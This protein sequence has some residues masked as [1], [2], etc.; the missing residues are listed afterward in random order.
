MSF[1]PIISNSISAINLFESILIL[2]KLRKVK[3]IK[4]YSFSSGYCAKSDKSIILENYFFKT[5]DNMVESPTTRVVLE[6]ISFKM[7]MELI[8]Q[9]SQGNPVDGKFVYSLHDIDNGDDDT[10]S[11]GEGLNFISGIELDTIT[12]STP[13]LLEYDNNRIFGAYSDNSTELSE[14]LARANARSTKFSLTGKTG[15]CDRMMLAYYQPLHASMKLVDEDDINLSGGKLAV[16]N[17]DE[18]IEEWDNNGEEKTI[19]LNPGEYILRETGIPTGYLGG[20]DV[21]FYIG[22]DDVIV[23]GGEPTSVVKVVDRRPDII[24]PI[25]PDPEPE[26]KPEPTPEP[27]SADIPEEKE[28]EV[29]NPNTSVI[30]FSFSILVLLLLIPIALLYRR[31]FYKV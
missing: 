29:E 16:Y 5:L 21:I 9:D 8:I 3:G 17:G 22:E 28:E 20:T 2:D 27:V 11:K 12:T 31:K 14:F 30:V 1:F 19:F 13:T 10:P 24:E 25:E 23:I 6:D 15:Y 4:I 26:P 18:L 7:D